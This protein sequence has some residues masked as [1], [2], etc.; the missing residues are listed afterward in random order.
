MGCCPSKYLF[1]WSKTFFDESKT[2][3]SPAV[4]RDSPRF[5]G[6]KRSN[7]RSKEILFEQQAV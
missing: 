5:I 4:E 6:K 7:D 1:A 3:S 2:C